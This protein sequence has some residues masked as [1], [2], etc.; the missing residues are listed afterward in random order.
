[1]F[2]TQGGVLTTEGVTIDESHSMGFEPCL[3]LECSKCF[4]SVRHNADELAEPCTEDVHEINNTRV[5]KL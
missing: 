4:L 5:V 1:M 2:Q 3:F